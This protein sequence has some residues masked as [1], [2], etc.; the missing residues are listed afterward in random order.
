MSKAMDHSDTGL[1]FPSGNISSLAGERGPYWQDLVAVVE[2]S[3]QD[4]P[5]Q[6][7]FL[8]M[9]ARLSSCANCNADSYRAIHGCTVCGRQSLKRFH[10][11]DK[12]LTGLYQAAKTEVILYLQK[13]S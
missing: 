7:A 4:S 8:L 3:G 12:D 6:M 1:I 2:N 13:K 10:G 9:M 11:S 5:E